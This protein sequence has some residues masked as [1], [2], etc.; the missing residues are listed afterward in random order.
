MT[1]SKQFWNNRYATGGNSG[2]GSYGEQL[3]WKLGWLSGLNIKTISEIGCGDFNFGKNLLDI[4]PYAKYTGEDFSD[5]IVEKNKKL[6]P[7]Q[8]F[9]TNLDEVPP[10]DLLLCVDVL[11]HVLDGEEL[12]KLLLELNY[13]WIKYLA[14]TAYERDEYLGTHVVVRK[15]DY[16]QFGEPIIREVVEEDGELYFYLFKK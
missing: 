3:A 8:T 1:D 16:K 11:F 12:K 15:F 2:Y 6:F 7:E 13:R 10:A 4:Y 14:I 5:V 9:T